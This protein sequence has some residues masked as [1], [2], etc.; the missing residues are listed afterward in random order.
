MSLHPGTKV[1]YFS[2][3]RSRMAY[4]S[5]VTSSELYEDWNDTRA[6]V[7]LRHAIVIAPK[8]H[9]RVTSSLNNKTRLGGDNNSVT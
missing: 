9:F 1:A 2:M 5:Y 6:C 3:S 4:F 7:G 8:P